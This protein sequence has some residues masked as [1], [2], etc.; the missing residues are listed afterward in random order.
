[1]RVIEIFNILIKLYY[2]KVGKIFCNIPLYKIIHIHFIIFIASCAQTGTVLTMVGNH[3]LEY[4]GNNQKW[5][6]TKSY[7]I[8]SADRFLLGPI[9]KKLLKV[10]VTRNFTQKSSPEVNASSL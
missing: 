10:L 6:C 9:F 7:V 2:H 4:Q 8:M 3:F 5:K 1:M